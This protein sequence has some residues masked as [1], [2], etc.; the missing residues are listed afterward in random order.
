MSI[1]RFQFFFGA[2]RFDNFRN[3]SQRLD[4]CRLAAVND[5]WQLFVEKF[6][7]PA[8][9]LTIDEQLL[10]YRGQIPGRTYT[11]LPSKPRRYELKIFW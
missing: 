9:I 10:G 3:R 11:Y 2:I 5:I 8:E 7:V 4:Q 1:N 6:Y